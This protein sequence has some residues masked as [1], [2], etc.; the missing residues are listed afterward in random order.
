MTSRNPTYLVAAG[1]AVL[2]CLMMAYIIA[3]VGLIAN[4]GDRADMVY[5]IV[6]ATGLVGSAVAR[7][8]P[9]GIAITLFIMAFAQAAIGAI[10]FLIGLQLVSLFTAFKVLALNGFFTAM[11]A[12]SGWLFLQSAKSGRTRAA[13]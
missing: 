5:L 8:R 11:F 7:L 9:L 2:A 3:A 12:G 10:T 1:V 4:E 13:G 6:F